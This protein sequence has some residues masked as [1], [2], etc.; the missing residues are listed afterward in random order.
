MLFGP[1]SLRLVVFL[2][3]DFVFLNGNVVVVAI[4]GLIRYKALRLG[5]LHLLLLRF[6]NRFEILVLVHLG[7]LILL[8]VAV[9]DQSIHLLDDASELLLLCTELA[10][11]PGEAEHH[12]IELL[13]FLFVLGL[14]AT[15][16]DTELVLELSLDVHLGGTLLVL[17]LAVDSDEIRKLGTLLA[18]AN[19]DN[20]P[21]D[22]ILEAVFSESLVI[23]DVLNLMG[24]AH[25]VVTG[26]L[27]FLLEDLVLV[28]QNVTAERLFFIL[29]D[30]FFH[31][32]MG[33]HEDFGVRFA[34]DVDVHLILH[35]ECAMVYR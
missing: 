10:L 15:I 19:L 26:E 13:V 35:K 7:K 28:D 23:S 33:E 34:S 2:L 32:S 25:D 6:L 4:V 20:E 21:Q 3:A 29:R 31:L 16:Q 14:F 5:L 12:I 24:E 8:F 9:V 17:L 11:K 27:P 30:K 18:F 1:F 22:N